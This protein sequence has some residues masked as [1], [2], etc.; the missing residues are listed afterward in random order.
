MHSNP[1]DSTDLAKIVEVVLAVHP[2]KRRSFVEAVR[3]VNDIT[4]VTAHAVEQHPFE[5]LICT[6][7]NKIDEFG[8]TFNTVVS[9][10]SILLRMW[11]F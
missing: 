7:V 2:A 3:L 4:D 11:L 6:H 5:Q 9:L 8:L 1:S 10:Y